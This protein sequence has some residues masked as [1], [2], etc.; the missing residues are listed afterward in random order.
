MIHK[1]LT[2][3]DEFARLASRSPD[4]FGVLGTKCIEVIAFNAESFC[5]LDS[6]GIPADTLQHMAAELRILYGN[7]INN[8]LP[9]VPDG[10]VILER[11]LGQRTDSSGIEEL[12]QQLSESHKSLQ[13]AANVCAS[14][15]SEIADLRGQ[16]AEAQRRVGDLEADLCSERKATKE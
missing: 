1:I 4:P 13:S 7:G 10:I 16:L 11:I 2:Q 8:G 9:T 6:S 15:V 12:R 5:Q 14:Q 3:G